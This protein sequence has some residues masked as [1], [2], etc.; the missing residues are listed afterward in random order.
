[1]F[2]CEACEGIRVNGLSTAMIPSPAEQN[3]CGGY[4]SPNISSK[5]SKLNIISPSDIVKLQLIFLSN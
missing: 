2:D 3:S 1:M 5:Y 4:S